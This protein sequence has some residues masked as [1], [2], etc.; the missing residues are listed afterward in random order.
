MARPNAT[1]TRSA[2]RER[3]AD[4]AP[5][6]TGALLKSFHRGEYPTFNVDGVSI[7]RDSRLLAADVLLTEYR[8]LKKDAR[9]RKIRRTETIG[10][11]VDP[12]TYRVF[13]TIVARFSNG[14][15]PGVVLG[16][17][18]EKFILLARP[19]IASQSGGPAHDALYEHDPDYRAIFE[20]T[21]RYVSPADEGG[22][23]ESAEP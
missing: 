17:M 13:Q 7:P 9:G 18:L 6:D 20:W 15:K 10:S 23:A 5:T 12:D 4:T 22:N 21:P 11:S 1:R 16:Q 14:K 19:Q 2:Q 8:P 3:R